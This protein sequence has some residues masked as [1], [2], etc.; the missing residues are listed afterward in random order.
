MSDPSA[1]TPSRWH[2]GHGELLLRHR[3]EAASIVNDI[4]IAIWFVAGSIMFFDPAMFT[5]G[6]WMFLLGS[7]ELAIR[8]TIRMIRYLHLSHR[9]HAAGHESDQDF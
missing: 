7:I 6:T 2:I 8:P 1:S 3:Y 5:A 4:L 9:H